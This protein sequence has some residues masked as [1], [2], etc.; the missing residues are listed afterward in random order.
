MVK[1]CENEFDVILMDI[2]M[3]EM[4]GL[5]AT[6]AIRSRRPNV[7]II[8]LSAHMVKDIELRCEGVGMNGYIAKPIDPEQLLLT[9]EKVVALNKQANAL[10]TGS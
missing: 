3:P 1:A 4:D 5:E 7:P 10:T 6:L 8:A 9:I 2:E